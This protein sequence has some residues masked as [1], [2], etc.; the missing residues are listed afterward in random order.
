MVPPK[1]DPFRDLDIYMGKIQ[2]N[3]KAQGRKEQDHDHGRS[4]IV[5]M[6][7]DHDNSLRPLVDI[8][9]SDEF[10]DGGPMG[11]FEL[12]PQRQKLKQKTINYPGF[13]PGGAK[14]EWNPP[15]TEKKANTGEKTTL[16][17]NTEYMKT[18]QDKRHEAV[19]K[20]SKNL[21]DRAKSGPRSV[22]RPC[23]VKHPDEIRIELQNSSN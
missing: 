22:G 5:D 11:V 23:K 16:R 12:S 20:E 4:G 2:K 6:T 1:H 17:R 3:E 9:E 8:K 15:W 18:E 10:N 13:N 21:M 14:F 19:R 7:N